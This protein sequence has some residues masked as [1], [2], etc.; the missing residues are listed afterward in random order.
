MAIN[1]KLTKQQQQ[2]LVAGV[3]GAGAFGY[4]YIAFFWLPISEKK[5]LVNKKIEETEAKID[6]ARSKAG[7]L[8]QLEAELV[9]LN[10]QASEAERRLPKKKSVPEILVTVSGLAQRYNVQLVSFT[11][12]KEA[13]KQFFSELSYPITIRGNYHSIGKFLAAV[14]LEE[15]IFNVENVVY[16]EPTSLDTGEMQVTFNLISYQYKG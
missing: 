5:E 6:K 10:E 16:S 2:M 8:H 7:R 11:P 14:A 15:R 4:I 12:G 1:I 13:P 9:R 3:L